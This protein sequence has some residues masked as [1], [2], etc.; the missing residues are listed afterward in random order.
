MQ[1]PARRCPSTLT[2]IPNALPTI[3]SNTAPTCEVGISKVDPEACR[4]FEHPPSSVEE[5]RQVS[6]IPFWERL[7]PKDTTLALVPVPRRHPYATASERFPTSEDI[8][9]VAQPIGSKAPIGRRGQ[10]Q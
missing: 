3:V 4:W 2:T 5:L 10:Q 1:I 7:E 6:N 8:L 9:F